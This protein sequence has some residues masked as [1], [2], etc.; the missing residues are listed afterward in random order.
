MPEILF[1]DAHILVV[2]KPVGLLSEST[3]SGDGLADLLAARCG[4][5]IGVVHRLDRGVG[6]V[7]VYAKTQTAAAQ[8]SEQVRIRA[9][10]K[11][12]LA[13]VHG[14]PTEDGGRLCDLLFHDRRSNKTFVA[15]RSRRGV[16]EAI[17]DYSLVKSIQDT[18]YG[19]ISLLDVHLLTGRTHQ[20]RVQFASRRHP[21]LGDRKYGAPS[22]CPIGLFC[23]GLTFLHPVTQKPLSFSA[24]PSGEPWDLVLE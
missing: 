23:A 2:R 24:F 6:G 14:R 12:Y 11:Q 10:K 19:E 13:L 18:P 20:V 4:G 15:D 5:Y 22:S 21:L 8:L 1:E 16:K 7:M 9:V 3:P 17:L